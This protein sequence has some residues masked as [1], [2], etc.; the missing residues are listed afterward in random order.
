MSWWA[1][2]PSRSAH[3]TGSS[4]QE[5]LLGEMR[6]GPLPQLPFPVPSLGSLPHPGPL[7]LTP[8]GSAITEAATREQI[9]GVPR[10]GVREGKKR[11]EKVQRGQQSSVPAEQT[12][13]LSVRIA[14]HLNVAGHHRML[15]RALA[16]DLR[17]GDA[18]PCPWHPP[19]GCRTGNPQ[20]PA[21]QELLRAEAASHHLPDGR[22]GTWASAPHP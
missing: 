7:P 9:L 14:R 11:P 13:P 19:P 2:P 1:C 17:G 21:A 4:G 5:A 10:G 15:R 6:G 20:G 22:T 12:S 8:P 3:G 16:P 18:G